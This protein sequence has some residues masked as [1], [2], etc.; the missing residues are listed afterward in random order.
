M[1]I[2]KTLPLLLL[3]IICVM[4][5]AYAPSGAADDNRVALVVDYGNSQVATR[6]VSFSEDHIS[7]FEALERTGLPVE[8]DFQTGGAAVCRIDD[9]GCPANDCFCS[10]RGGGDC[11]YWSYWHLNNG[12][13]NYSAAGS[14]LY[15]VRDGAVEGWVWGLGSITQASPPPLVSF[16]DIC[17][18][19]PANTPTSTITPSPTFTP[20]FL[21]T[22]QPTAPISIATAAGTATANPTE[23]S[24]SLQQ[25]PPDPTRPPVDA[26]TGTPATSAPPS[27]QTASIPSTFTPSP[28]SAVENAGGVFSAQSTPPQPP[29]LG[30]E[31]SNDD[32]TI[33]S[34][35]PG[36]EPSETRAGSVTTMSEPAGG[37][38]ESTANMPVDA[39]PS[40]P[41]AVAVVGA[42]ANAAGAAA[43]V[44]AVQVD[45]SVNTNS[46][47]GFAGLLL[48]L[49]ALT[50]LVYRRRA[51]NQVDR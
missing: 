35:T 36:T 16:G 1:S 27:R 32:Q 10:C 40:L 9:Q 39:T 33:A 45:N 24:S 7:G 29:Y 34:S 21:P 20:I 47:A 41:V 2:A 11:I 13:W 8:T 25:T 38:I 6:C 31:Q 22:A 12:A 14:G 37:I 46:Y 17:V 50:L 48:L 23:A 3:T 26:D 43:P 49:L 51:T 18:D 44:A 5:F 19:A 15:E 4:L 30:T 42:D 28:Q